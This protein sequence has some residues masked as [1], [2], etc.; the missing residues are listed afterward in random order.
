MHLTLNKRLPAAN[1][2]QKSKINESVALMM[3]IF[4]KQKKKNY[5]RDFFFFASLL[6]YKFIASYVSEHSLCAIST[7]GKMIIDNDDNKQTC[8]FQ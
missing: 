1:V 7:E 8:E 4:N 5:I 2:E 3:R 6:T